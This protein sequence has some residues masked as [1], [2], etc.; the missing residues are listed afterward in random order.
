MI[1]GMGLSQYCMHVCI[2]SFKASRLAVATGPVHVAAEH[3]RDT[4]APRTWGRVGRGPDGGTTC[5]HKDDSLK[6]RTSKT[7][8]CS[9][10]MN[11]SMELSDHHTANG[12][13]EQPKE[14]GK[15]S[16]G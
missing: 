5:T 12:R 14:D 15:Q 8:P 6:E 4:L 1:R 11:V 3:V 13:L 7:N 16:M 9:C 2:G 10:L